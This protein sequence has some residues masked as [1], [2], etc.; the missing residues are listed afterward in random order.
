[1]K[2]IIETV[3]NK[4]ISVTIHYIFKANFNDSFFLEE[5]EIDIASLNRDELTWFDP[6]NGRNSL[7]DTRTAIS[8]CSDD[9]LT[10]LEKT[11]GVIREISEESIYDCIISEDY[12][13]SMLIASHIRLKYGN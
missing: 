9:R 1:M 10:V 6:Y 12:D 5:F 3:K 2:P 8:Y 7:S 4:K 13:D 11:N